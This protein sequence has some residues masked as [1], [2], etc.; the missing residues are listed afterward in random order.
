MGKSIVYYIG[1]SN[2]IAV[3]NWALGLFNYFLL[4]MM[5]RHLLGN[6]VLVKHCIF[7]QCE[8]VLWR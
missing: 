7:A 5:Y 6:H 3:G 8:S 4:Q 2:Y 1:I